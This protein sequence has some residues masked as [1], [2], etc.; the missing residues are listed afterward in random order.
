MQAG[1]HRFD[2]DILHP[3]LEAR[4]EA[5]RIFV[6][7]MP[8][9]EEEDECV[10]LHSSPREREITAKRCRFRFFDMIKEKERACIVQQKGMMQVVRK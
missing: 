9:K 2:S 8:C 1:G 7:T 3:T 10:F 6:W 4:A 5:K